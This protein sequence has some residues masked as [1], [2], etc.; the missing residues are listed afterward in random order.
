[1]RQM[2]SLSRMFSWHQSFTISAPWKKG[3]NTS[4]SKV[5]LT[6][7]KVISNEKSEGLGQC[8]PTT[9]ESPEKPGP[10]ESSTLLDL[11]ATPQ[12]PE[13]TEHFATCSGMPTIALKDQVPR[14]D[15]YESEDSAVVLPEGANLPSTLLGSGKNFVLHSRDSSCDSGVLS[16]S[17]SPAADHIKTGKDPVEAR[18]YV[19]DCKEPA[20]LC[21]GHFGALQMSALSLD[22]DT[23][24]REAKHSEQSFFGGS[25]GECS[26]D[27]ISEEE[28]HP[29][30]FSTL[31]VE[32]KSLRDNYR[33]NSLE[34]LPLQGQPLRKHSTSDSLDEYMDACCRLSK[35]NEGNTK[36]Y[37]SGLGYLEHICQLIE[38][39]GQLQEQN[40]KLQKEICSLQKEQKTNQLKEEYFLQHC[41]CGAASFLL[42]SYQEAKNSF[43]GWNTRP[44]SLL[45][46]NG[47]ISDLSVIPETGGNNERSSKRRGSCQILQ[48]F[49]K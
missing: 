26:Q 44:H 41:S 14:L 3:K 33:N 11:Q 28:I 1:M 15:T 27:K 48:S 9:S 8:P 5:V 34:E 13:E 43:P 10:P 22:E 23:D 42:S 18:H 40:L 29:S 20:E 17:S 39:I 19:S 25:Q 7:M 2:F 31:P 46:Q 32:E 45:A 16:A 30:C 37:S 36:T 4:D 12:T 49:L 38:K 47:I 6:N 21:T 24:C 35:V